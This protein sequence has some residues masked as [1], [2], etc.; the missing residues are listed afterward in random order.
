MPEATRSTA[1]LVI[2]SVDLEVE[3]CVI[4][5][6]CRICAC[7]IMTELWT[8]SAWFV[9]VFQWSMS[10]PHNTRGWS[11][12]VI[13]KIPTRQI[14]VFSKSTQPKNNSSYAMKSPP[15]AWMTRTTKTTRKR[16]DEKTPRRWQWIERRQWQKV[17]RS[18][19]AASAPLF[20][21]AR[22]RRSG[23]R[24]RHRGSCRG[25]RSYRYGD[26]CG[27]Q[28][29]GR[30]SRRCCSVD[31]HLSYVLLSC[32]RWLLF[33]DC[34]SVLVLWWWC[35]WLSYCSFEVSPI[36]LVRFACL[37]MFMVYSCMFIESN[38]LCAVATCLFWG[39]W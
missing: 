34:F 16:R 10:E 1:E 11:L 8:A 7:R 2:V 23:V 9:F 32:F 27:G 38:V 20:G 15:A 28:C 37:L 4:Y 12:I 25:R 17:S 19:F 21:P 30:G 24:R 18:E 39:L 31:V 6:V 33:F 22:K 36:V 13:S 3:V 29:A 14:Y 26:G 35:I 5:T